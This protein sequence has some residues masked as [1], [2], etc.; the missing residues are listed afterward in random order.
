MSVRRSVALGICLPIL[1]GAHTAPAASWEPEAPPRLDVDWLFEN[2]VAQGEAKGE[3]QTPQ[4]P[5]A[6][7]P[8]AAQEPQAT[9]PV[10][11]DVESYVSLGD[12][13]VMALRN[14]IDLEL[15]R[16]EP[17]IA[18]QGVRAARGAFDPELAA[19]WNFN[20]EESPVSNRLEAGSSNA[21]DRWSYGSGFSGLLP[22]GMTYSSRIAMDR[23]QLGSRNA[24]FEREFR[25]RWIS[26]LTV[27]LLRDFRV[28]EPKVRVVR[29]ELGH[30]ISEDVFATRT[31]DIVAGVET[32]YWDLAAA[33]AEVNV[34]Q[35]SLRTAQDLLEQ[36]RVQQEVGVVSRVAVTQ[37]EAGVAERELNA[38][39]S[40]NQAELAKDRLLNALLAPDARAYEDREVI[41][42]VPTFS[43]YNVD[44]TKAVEVAMTNR[45]DLAEARKRLEIA[46]LEQ[47]LAENQVRPR[48]DLVAGY[49]SSGLSGR[50]RPVQRRNSSR[51]E[52]T[53]EGVDDGDPQDAFCDGLTRDIASTASW[54]SFDQFLRVGGNHGFSVQG[55]FAMTLGNRAAEANV[56]QRA[57]ELRRS[58]ARLRQLEQ[59]VLLNVREAVRGIDSAAKAVSAAERRRAASTE[60]LRAEQERLRLGDS[61]PFQVLEFEEDL[62][63]AERQLI[64]SLRSH[65][66]ALTRIEQAQGTLLRARG[67]DIDVELDREPLQ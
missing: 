65:R 63:E 2:T 42:E 3:A 31:I 47:D 25:G 6:Q 18:E 7:T 67:I 21:N 19:N 45:P 57:I 36:T 8:A 14:N 62:A 41:P 23:S 10:D 4:G 12:A 51:F 60:T 37:A 13:L 52:A 32:L 20:H 54:D 56:T 53:C 50:A 55:Q 27:P 59:T 35:K 49:T 5:Q 29:S 40:E 39:V 22:F 38:I 66:N 15:A 43:E 16:V 30:E 61:T 9:G 26:E 24:S 46:E 48:F 28:N 33:R 11:P 58:R 64:D 34:A 1:A 17:A 44:M